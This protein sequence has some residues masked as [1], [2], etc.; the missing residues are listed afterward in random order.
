MHNKDDEIEETDFDFRL[1]GGVTHLVETVIKELGVG[2]SNDRLV[3]H[4][5]PHA[6]PQSQSQSPSPHPQPQKK[7]ESRE[8]PT[9]FIDAQQMSLDRAI[10]NSLITGEQTPVSVPMS[11]P[12][13]AT[14]PNPISR[15]P[16]MSMSPLSPMA[17]L[18]P[19]P[20][21]PGK[22]IVGLPAEPSLALDVEAIAAKPARTPT[23]LP[24]PARHEPETVGLPRAFWVVALLLVL[25]VLAYVIVR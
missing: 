25:I 22:V 12:A 5:Q 14:P 1:P 6:K 16:S 3:P 24:P 8:A 19:P 23:W 20:P 2:D 9:L 10:S 7:P 17:P 11:M 13:I 18:A 15:M 21:S 4:P